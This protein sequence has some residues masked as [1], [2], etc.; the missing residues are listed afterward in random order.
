[1]S[2]KLIIAV[3][4]GRILKE[5]IPVF[6]KAGIV[7]KK[8][9]FDPDSRLLRF[10]TNKS[11]VDI[12]RVR[13]FD[14]VTFVAFGAAAIGVAGSDVVTEFDNNEVYSLLDLGI[15]KCRMSVAATKGLIKEEDPSRW[16]HIRVATK[17]PRTTKDFFAKRGVQTECVKLNGAMELAPK[18]GLC[19]R[20]VDLVSTGATL[21]S[22]GL[23]EVEKIADISSR[24]IINR[25]SLK[26]RGDEI[27]EIVESFKGAISG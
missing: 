13:S 4:K 26:T 9:F 5:L 11:N 27:N 6:E 10:E 21:K 3:P 16:S 8:E 24:L 15:G 19:R 1:M 20:I 12:I 22:N 14:A 23:E 7:P 17:Y 2:D 25:T 18:L